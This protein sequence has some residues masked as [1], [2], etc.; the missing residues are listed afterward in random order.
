MLCHAERWRD[1]VHSADAQA[2]RDALSTASAGGGGTVKVSGYCAGAVLQDGTAQVVFIT[3]T[4]T[5]AGGYTTTNW[6]TY[7][8]TS[9]PTT[10]D[11]LAGGRVIS[12]DVPAT[13][14]GFTVTN[15]YISSTLNEN[16]GGIF[17]ADALTLTD[18]MV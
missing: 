16:G 14:Q 15:G 6:T 4:I 11:A 1:G 12:A 9:N 18:M 8:P 10:L 5:I 7:N 2:V 3:Q 17:A 13:L